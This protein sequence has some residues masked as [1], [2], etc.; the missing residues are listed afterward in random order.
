MMAPETAQYLLK[1][2][3]ENNLTVLEVFLALADQKAKQVASEHLSNVPDTSRPPATPVFTFPP[4]MVLPTVSAPGP[5]VGSADVPRPVVVSGQ[6]P[7][8]NLR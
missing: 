6:D 1:L 4:V 3:M 5:V 2:A 7:D 8:L